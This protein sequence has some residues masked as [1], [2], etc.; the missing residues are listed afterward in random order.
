MLLFCIYLFDCSWSQV[1]NKRHCHFTVD[2]LAAV[3]VSLLIC[4]Y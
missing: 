4:H 2:R 1:W 3:T